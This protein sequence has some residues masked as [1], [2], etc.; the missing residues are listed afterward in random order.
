[1][2]IFKS[3]RTHLG[4]ALSLCV[5]VGVA[6]AGVN[7]PP[8][9]PAPMR[10]AADEIA[11]VT[12]GKPL[13]VEVSLEIQSNGVAQSYRI[14]RDGAKIRVIGGDAVGAMYG[15]LDIAEAIRTDALDSLKNSDHTPRIEQRGLKFNIPLDVRTPTYNKGEW[16]DSARLNV[17]VMWDRD[18]WRETFD[19]MARH[20]YNVI[21]FWNLNP[22]PSLVNVPEFPHVALENVESTDAQ[23]G[24]HVVVKIMTMA[25]KIQ[26]WRD[27]MQ[28]A[29]DRG[30]DV[31]WM[32]W[33]VF[34]EPAAGKDGLTLNKT[35]PNSI[36][37]FRDSVRELVTTYP[38]LAGL[39]VTAGENMPPQ[40]FKKISKEDWL[41]QTYGEGIRD[42]LK[43][44]PDRKFRLVH[45]FHQTSFSNLKDA[46]KELPCQLDVSFKYAVAH[47]YSITNP[48]FIKPVLPFLSPALRTW[49]EIRNDDIHSFR[50]ADVD[51]ARDFM[52]EIPG[53]GK[54]IG[55]NMGP[56]GYHWGLD[57][58]TKN[59]DGPRQTFIH[60]QWLSFDLWG[61]L[62]YDPDLPTEIFTREVTA[63][64]PGA[65][66]PK[67]MAAWGDASM[68]FPCITRFFWG[69]IDVKWFPEACRKKGGFYT[70]KDFIE[71][72]TMPGA[73]V[74]N[75]GEWRSGLLAK[76]MPA[77]ITPLR[78]ADTLDANASASLKVLP[79]LRRATVTPA[80]SAKEYAAT[81]D[82]I[83]AM[84][85][86]GLYYAEKIRGACDLAL[87]DKSG[88][89]KDQSSAVKHLEAAVTHWKNYA[90]AYT[91]QYVQPV[92]FN[93][94]GLVDLPKE[95]THVAADVTLARDWKPGT[96]H[97]QNIKHSR[98]EAGFR[99]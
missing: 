44:T 51:F 69:D 14:E 3:S 73:N 58:L 47:M 70:V 81:L 35:A 68:T 24:R 32:L 12:G 76:K 10:F 60:K 79:E 30:V 41:W 77:G 88:D 48:P 54:I 65:D 25:E 31:Y 52:K 13:A 78:I 8:N 6:S 45:R 16:P 26:F 40:E 33:N 19:D 72:D 7:L 4:I 99:E 89:A 71:G 18:F 29:K 2:K 87:F 23:T 97:E 46:F 75:I 11:R 9:A 82:D 20:R 43:A 39:G 59:P 74:L 49:L 36:A 22:F 66:A 67:L 42:G 94:A 80:A 56:D 61:R 5:F 28:L 90:A 84:A 37:Y 15:G 17:P 95:T 96:I 27:V 55:F 98:T 50:W 53:P 91:R 21:Y 38:L 57:F 62:A 34:L 93:R 63:R 64:F 92:L 1:M 85:D 86:L 83:E